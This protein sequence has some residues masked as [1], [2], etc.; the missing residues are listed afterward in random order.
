M[1]SVLITILVVTFSGL[2]VVTNPTMDT[3]EQFVYQQVIQDA[4]K[5][6]EL[7]QALGVLFGG[8]S[9]HLLANATIR[10]N[11]LLL[12]VYDMDFGNDHLRA[13]GIFNHFI[14]LETSMSRQK[15][16]HDTKGSTN[17]DGSSS[18]GAS[19]QTKTEIHS[20]QVRDITQRN[21]K[22]GPVTVSTYGKCSPIM[23]NCETDITLHYGDQSLEIGP[24][25]GEFHPV[26]EEGVSWR[27]NRYVTI[28]YKNIGNCWACEG[29]SVSA[30][31]GG[32][33]FYLGKFSGFEDIYLFKVYNG[34]EDN[35][36]TSHAKSPSWKLYFRYNKGKAV[37][38]I[39]KT[40]LTA[41]ADY[42]ADKKKLLHLLVT[43]EKFHASSDEGEWLFEDNIKAPLLGTLAL[44]RY[45][46][47]Q[48][49]YLEVLKVAKSNPELVSWE[50]LRNL[51]GELSRVQQ[52]EAQQ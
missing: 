42:D 51:S 40:C 2:L 25:E 41:K 8:I 14:I 21:F 33:L 23:D 29:I 34:L 15:T 38:D 12:S 39:N 46:G 16:K 49:D 37:L 47:W 22:A 26:Y 4:T 5:Q 44:A 20:E 19:D 30:L 7:S 45:C 27:D 32:K 52:V 43:T 36:L 3:Y 50:V 6:G 11:Y 24:V 9:S 35:G 13:L 17:D 28:D 18:H 1:K 31:D 48:N 10:H